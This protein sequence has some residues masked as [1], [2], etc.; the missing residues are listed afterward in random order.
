MRG[1][2]VLTRPSSISG[3]PVTSEMSRTVRPPLASACAC[4]AGG[5]QFDVEGG[6]AASQI[7]KAGLVADA[8]QG[9]ADGAEGHARVLP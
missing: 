8:E 6:E 2:S 1:C 5:N 4:A 3:K 9:A 7:E